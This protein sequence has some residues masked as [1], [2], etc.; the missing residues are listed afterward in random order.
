MIAWLALR[1]LGNRLGLV[2]ESSDYCGVRL[3]VLIGLSL[4][5]TSLVRTSWFLDTVTLDLPVHRNLV[6]PRA[7]RSDGL[8]LWVL[9]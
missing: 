6:G 1:Q 3:E 2:G 4:I 8:R 7:E 5:D 9:V